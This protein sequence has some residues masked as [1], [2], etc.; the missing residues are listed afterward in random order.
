[1]PRSLNIYNDSCCSGG[2]EF[3][4]QMPRQTSSTEEY[5]P[6]VLPNLK[7]LRDGTDR[8]STTSSGYTEI[9]EMPGTPQSSKR[10]YTQSSIQG[11]S[12]GSSQGWSPRHIQGS[13][14]DSTTDLRAS[15]TRSGYLIPISHSGGQNNY[16]HLR[17]QSEAPRGNYTGLLNPYATQD[18]AVG[19][20]V[21]YS[22]VSFDPSYASLSEYILPDVKPE[23]NHKAEQTGASGQWLVNS[24]GYINMTGSQAMDHTPTDT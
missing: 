18:Q 10:G 24:D 7:Y 22:Y 9:R 11:F 16:E 12:P 2:D 15:S 17:Q 8:Y 5:V 4:F 21:A 20:E 19:G 13:G 1:M 23:N 6:S 3:S 14:R